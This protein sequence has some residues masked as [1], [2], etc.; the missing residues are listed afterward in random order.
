MYYNI[1]LFVVI[2]FKSM[3]IYNTKWTR[4]IKLQWIVFL[5]VTMYYKSHILPLLILLYLKTTKTTYK[6]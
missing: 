5:I 4:C 2:A 3:M 6:Y 1:Y